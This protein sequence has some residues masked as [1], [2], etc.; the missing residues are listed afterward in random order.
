MSKRL[1][2][3]EEM[4]TTN[5][6]NVSRKLRGKPAQTSKTIF[7]PAGLPHVLKTTRNRILQTRASV[8]VPLKL[9]LLMLPHRNLHVKPGN[10][11]HIL[12]QIQ[13]DSRHPE[14]GKCSTKS[15]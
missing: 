10:M 3:L 13:W 12:Q 11:S 5:L 9:P 4:V 6:R 8:R 14:I 15:I 2:N 7:T 1:R